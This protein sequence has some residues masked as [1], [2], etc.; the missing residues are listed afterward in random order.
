[1][2]FVQFEKKSTIRARKRQKF[3]KHKYLS[4]QELFSGVI[5]SVRFLL[6]I[7][8]GE[9]APRRQFLQRRI[10]LCLYGS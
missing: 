7:K 8:F 4:S 9:D 6:W 3:S 1:M 2:S 5:L 10:L